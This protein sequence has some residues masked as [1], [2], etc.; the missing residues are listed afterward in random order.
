MVPEAEGGRWGVLFFRA[1]ERLLT[2]ENFTCK[3]FMEPD[4][5]KF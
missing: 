5:R 3:S 4:L 1:R 2:G